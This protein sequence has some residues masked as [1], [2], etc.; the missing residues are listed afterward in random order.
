M[1]LGSD[2][3][4]DLTWWHNFLDTWNGVGILPTTTTPR[5]HLYTN[6]SGTWGY[7]GTMG[8]QMVP[9]EMGEPVRK[10]AYC[11]KGTPSNSA[12]RFAMGEIVVRYDGS[13]PL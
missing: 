13:M 11:T 8:H 12:G 9:V 2:V 6:A 1:R 7:A 3:R 10:M 5:L 4:S